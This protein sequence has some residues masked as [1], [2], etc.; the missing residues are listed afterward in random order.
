VNPYRS[1]VLKRE[2]QIKKKKS[3]E[4]IQWII[5]EQKTIFSAG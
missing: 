5:P 2:L 4:S 1:A 3:Q